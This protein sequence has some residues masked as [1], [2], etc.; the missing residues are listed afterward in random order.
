MKSINASLIWFG[1]AVSIAEII[2]GTYLAPLGLKTG[3]AAILLGHLIGCTLLFFA[4][5]IG[6]KTNKSAMETTKLSFGQI[7]AK[8]FA[9]LNVI[10]LVGWTSIMIYDGALSVNQIIS[11][12]KW[13]WALVIGILIALWIITG[14]T[15]I[16][17]F[18]AVIITALFVLTLVLCKVVFFTKGI[19]SGLSEAV[20][21]A[22]SFGAA[23][24]L[25]C[26]MPLSWLPLISDYTKDSKKPFLV[27]LLSA[28]VYGVISSW[29]YFIGMGAA[30]FTGEGDVS[31]IMVKA[32]LG[33]AALVIIILSTV[34]TTFL[35]AFSSGLSF[36]TINPKAS[37]K[38][39]S[40][41]VTVIGTVLA[42]LL[43]MDNITNFLY[44]I[45]SVFAPMIAI[46]LADFFV[47]KSDSSEKSIDVTK[48]L[49][50]LVGFVVYRELMKI[51]LP[52][53][54]TLPSMMITFVLTCVA[55][56]ITKKTKTAE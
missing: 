3:L 6:A 21:E 26:A 47:L 30:I 7:G 48:M 50:W 16:E 29:M 52:L 13:I 19:T 9:L 53:G 56:V 32:G 5:Y 20:E 25:S 45:G 18:N 36:Q 1:A 39:V 42:I 11:C 55:R 22:M 43:P 31:A 51:D 46:Q 37:V 2:T 12:G 17:K 40:I 49:L 8:F 54:N 28:L 24:E 33:T 27:T 35:D 34:T 44:F 4:G 41:A 14:I 10:Q 23:V 38:Y 15:N